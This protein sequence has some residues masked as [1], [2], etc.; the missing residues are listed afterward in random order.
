MHVCTFDPDEALCETYE[1]SK[2]THKIV[3]KCRNLEAPI[4]V[5]RWFIFK[6]KIPIWTKFG[7][8]WNGKYLMLGIF[9]VI[10]YKL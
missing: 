1:L 2:R 6:P 7:G 5:A 4:R 3:F 8:P 9:L 10:W